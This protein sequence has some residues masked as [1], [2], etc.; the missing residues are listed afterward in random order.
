MSNKVR[1]I[2]KIDILLT[3]CFSLEIV[4]KI[5]AFGFLFNG[6]KSYMRDPWNIFDFCLVSVSILGRTLGESADVGFIISLRSL[7]ML[8]PLRIISRNDGL[9]VSIASLGFSIPA[10]IRLLA[11][12]VFYVFLFAVLQSTILSGQFY[13]C[14]M[15]H[16]GM[17]KQ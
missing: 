8:R 15:D 16:L 10:I 5:I 17:S 14:S 11:M 7:R 12:V 2:D 6:P 13:H 1:V 4:F 3:V 9:R